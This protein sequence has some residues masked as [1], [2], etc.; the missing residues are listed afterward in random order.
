MRKSSSNRLRQ[1]LYPHSHTSKVRRFP[2]N[3]S[4]QEERMS[5]RIIK[6]FED[7]VNRLLYIAVADISSPK[8]ILCLA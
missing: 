3:D 7:G 8:S 1:H 6:S 5:F 4:Q 2:T